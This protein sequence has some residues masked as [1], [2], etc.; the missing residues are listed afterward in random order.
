MFM[1]ISMKPSD[2]VKQTNPNK[3][4]SLAFSRVFN[5]AAVLVRRVFD[6]ADFSICSLERA[7]ERTQIKRR[8]HISSTLPP[9]AG[10]KLQHIS[11]S[12]R[13]PIKLWLGSKILSLYQAAHSTSETGSVTAD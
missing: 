10:G 5:A 13:S 3:S 1:H 6:E 12:A 7:G 2:S 4:S 9:E 11:L 8:Y